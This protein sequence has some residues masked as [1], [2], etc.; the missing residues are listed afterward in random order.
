MKLRRSHTQIPK[1]THA[2]EHQ[3]TPSNQICIVTYNTHT[4]CP[5]PPHCTVYVHQRFDIVLH[6]TFNSTTSISQM[7]TKQLRPSKHSLSQFALRPLEKTKN[8]EHKRPDT[9][10]ST[11][12]LRPLAGTLRTMSFY[13]GPFSI[14]LKVFPAFASLAPSL[15]TCLHCSTIPSPQSLLYF[16]FSV[17]FPSL[18]SSVFHPPPFFTLHSSAL[19]TSLLCTSLLSPLCSL[20]C[21]ASSLLYP[22][23]STPS[24]P[25]LFPVLLLTSSLSSLLYSLHFPHPAHICS[26]LP[27][28]SSS[29]SSSLP[30][31]SLIVSLHFHHLLASPLLPSLLTS[32]Y[33]SRLYSFHFTSQ[34]FWLPYSSLRHLL[35]LYSMHSAY[36]LHFPILLVH[37]YTVTFC[38]LCTSLLCHLHFR[39][40]HFPT[41]YFSTLYFSRLFTSLPY[42]LPFPCIPFPSLH[43]STLTLLLLD[44]LR[45]LHFSTLFASLLSSVSTLHICA[46]PLS[47]S[48]LLYF[49]PLSGFFPHIFVRGSCFPVVRSRLLLLLLAAPSSPPLCHTQLSHTHTHNLVTHNC[50]TRNSFT[51]SLLTQLCHT[52]LF[53]KQ[54]CDTTLSHTTL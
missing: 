53:H 39:T 46:L 21:S 14:V 11:T 5:C 49:K 15:F 51:H 25:L 47:T 29:L 6:A 27:L 8:H 45:A 50:F 18:P 19:F 22:H 24:T 30:Y 10:G 3:P 34:I 54:L 44:A 13:S 41:L 42:S 16:P 7:R 37:V 48:S 12:N 40:F 38:T 43:F 9:R 1:K 31:C 17:L 26:A 33:A 28:Y 20:Q 2:R 23:F 36:S 35:L 52:Q 4:K 32:L